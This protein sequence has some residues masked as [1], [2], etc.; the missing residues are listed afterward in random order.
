LSCHW[1]PLE[2]A[3]PHPPDTHPLAWLISA[4]SLSVEGRAREQGQCQSTYICAYPGGGAEQ[5]PRSSASCGGEASGTV[6]C[7]SVCPRNAGL[8]GWQQLTASL[9]SC[10]LR[11]FP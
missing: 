7:T 4:G 2:R 5:D 1:T 6:F 3:W 8:R 9:T 11:V 10:H